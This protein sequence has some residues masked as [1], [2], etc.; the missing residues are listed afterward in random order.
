[1]GKQD[2]KKLWFFSIKG[3]KSLYDCSF[4]PGETLVFGK[5]TKGLP[6]ELLSSYPERVVRVPFQGPVRSLNLSN[7][8]AIALFEALRQNLYS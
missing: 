4:K 1:M 5:E 2:S 6:P 8:V 7:A 3:K